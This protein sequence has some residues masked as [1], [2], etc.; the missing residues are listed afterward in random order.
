MSNMTAEAEISKADEEHKKHREANEA[1]KKALLGKTVRMTPSLS[2][3]QLNHHSHRLRSP[4]TSN[5]EHRNYSHHAGS[6]LLLLTLLN[7]PNDRQNLFLS[8]SP[9]SMSPSHR[10]ALPLR[11]RVL[12]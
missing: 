3:A 5:P 11:L 12:Q 9:R 1:R 6:S 2:M 4:K 7:K 8:L 10:V